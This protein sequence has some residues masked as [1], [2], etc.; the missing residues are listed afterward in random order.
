VA[1]ITR[2]RAELACDGALNCPDGC[3]IYQRPLYGSCTAGSTT[4][5]GRMWREGGEEHR[6]IMTDGAL[7]CQWSAL[8]VVGAVGG[9]AVTGRATRR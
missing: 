4:E 5:M 8:S 2:R 6:Y 9:R 3:G 7:A 1:S